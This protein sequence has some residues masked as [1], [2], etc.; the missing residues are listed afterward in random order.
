MYWAVGFAFAF[1]GALGPR[2]R[3]HRLLPA[4]LRRSADG[5]PDHG[6]LRRDRSRRSGSSSS[7]F[8][9]VSLAIV[10]GTT[11]ERIKFGVYIIYAIVFVGA[12]LP[13]RLGLGLRRRLAAGQRRHAGLRRLDGRPPDRRDRRAR[14]AA[15]ARRRAAASTARTASRGRSR[16]TTCRC[17]ASACCILLARLVR[18]QPGLDARTRSTAAS[19]R[20]LLVTQLAAARRRARRAHHR[21]YLKT[22]TIDIGM[23]GNGAI[24]A[25]VAITA[26]VGLRRRRGPASSSASSP[27]SSSPLGVYAIDKKLDDPVGA[28]TAHGLCGVW[29]TL[30]CGLFTAAGARRVQRRRRAAAC[31]TRARSTQLGAQALGVVDRLRVRLRDQLRDV[32]A[33]QE[34]LRP[35]RHRRGGG[36]RPRHLRA[37]HVRLPGAVHPGAG[38]RGLRCGPPRSACAPAT[39][40]HRPRRCTA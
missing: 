20:S 21:A 32:L 28:L 27:A 26:P 10:W 25:L 1:G 11:L 9:A 2:H 34:D 8:C 39:A 13:D 22:K 24:G 12:H 14:G 29:G 16:A 18:V 35:A 3:R 40:D 6:P 7:S 33:H 38:A 5:L 23:A 30:S 36:R 15:A 4:R 31:S 37:R 17:S 19:R